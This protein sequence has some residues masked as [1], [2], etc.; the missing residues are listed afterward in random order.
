VWAGPQ[1]WDN[2]HGVTQAPAVKS[3]L[4]E[5]ATAHLVIGQ[6][7]ESTPPAS[8]PEASPDR[9][10]DRTRDLFRTARIPA[11]DSL[12]TNMSDTVLRVNGDEQDALEACADRRYVARTRG[13][14]AAGE[15][16]IHDAIET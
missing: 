7:L 6:W 2:Y 5:A 15:S 14:C 10:R 12:G 8:T 11:A 16:E 3:G 13:R 4:S 1:L 9:Q